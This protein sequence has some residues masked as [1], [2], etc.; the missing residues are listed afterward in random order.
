MSSLKGDV[1]WD[2]DV[3]IY[4]IVKITGIYWSKRGDSNWNPYA[5]LKHDDDWTINIYDVVRCTGNFRAEWD[6]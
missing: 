2:G 3:D 6:C 4:D 5:D 1:D